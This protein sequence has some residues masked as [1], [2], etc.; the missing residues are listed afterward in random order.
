MRAISRPP[1]PFFDIGGVESTRMQWNEGITQ[2]VALAELGQR[3]RRYRLAD[4]EA[5]EAMAGSLRRWGQLAPVVA[6]VRR[7]LGISS[8]KLEERIVSDFGALG[9]LEGDDLFCCLGT[10]RAK[11]GSAE[12]FRQVDFD[13]PLTAARAFTGRK[14]LLVSST[15]ANARSPFL[16]PR[17][18]G[19][20]EAAVSALPFQEVHIFRP[21]FLAGDRPEK[22]TVE[23]AS[24][25]AFSFQTAILAGRQRPQGA[26]PSTQ[27]SRRGQSGNLFISID[28]E[29]AV[30]LQTRF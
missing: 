23:R 16:Y 28:N 5:E 26:N 14:F 11:A 19:E 7:P 18:K 1:F 2:P 30:F 13:I 8:P 15:G 17:T 10:T 25:A 20:L 24:I 9:A 3:Y 4:P 12:A 22:R 27:R 6:C 21:S 29:C